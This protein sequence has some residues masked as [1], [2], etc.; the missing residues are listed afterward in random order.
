M[1]LSTRLV[2]SVAL[3]VAAAS[4]A[5]AEP[6]D[7]GRVP[8]KTVWMM[9][10]D[11]DAARESTVVKRMVE[12]AMNKHPQLGTML[13]IGAKMMGMDIRKDLHD[14]TVYGLDTD[15]K[16]AVMVVHADANR[17]MLEKMVDKAPDHKTMQHRDFT[18]HQWT[19]KGWKGRGGDTVVGAFFKDD[20]MVFAR[21]ASQVEMALDVLAGEAEAVDGDSPLAGRV[22][23]GSI[24]VGRAVAID[25]DTKCPVLKQGRGY[26]IAM[27][28]SD[29]MSFYRARL[30][31]DSEEAARQAEAVTE[32][33]VAL[34]KLRFGDEE[35]VMK[36]IDGVE[37]TTS[38]ST[39]SI[40]WNAKADDVWTVAEKMAEKM[41]AKMAAHR[42]QW[43]GRQSGCG[44]DGCSECEKG[45]CP[46][47][48]QGSA[49]NGA[50]DDGRRPFRDDEF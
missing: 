40:A 30:E 26:R 47:E 12:R 50:K 36:L 25:P 29:G 3:V 22:R 35:Q 6:L 48:K 42:R 34:G 37:T 32:G 49:E 44:K 4:V 20:V 24:L 39:C 19:H 15:K 21:S 11:M 43:G 23:P 14:V 2:A 33:F 13:G 28:E 16:N 31:M 41:E 38:G 7:L 9:H 5:S 45:K 17:A 10:A 46:M 18:L 8:A 27:G 1:S